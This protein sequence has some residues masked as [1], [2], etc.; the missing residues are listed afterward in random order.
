MKVPAE[1]LMRTDSCRVPVATGVLALVALGEIAFCVAVNYLTIS[2]ARD[3]PGADLEWKLL[4]GAACVDVLTATY[5]IFFVA[6]RVSYA[7]ERMESGHADQFARENGSGRPENESVGCHLLVY[8]NFVKYVIFSTIGCSAFIVHFFRTTE[9]SNLVFSSSAER[10]LVISL[11]S[12]ALI[13]AVL[14]PVYTSVWLFN[15]DDIIRYLTGKPTEAQP[16]SSVSTGWAGM[17]NLRPKRSWFCMIPN[18]KPRV[19]WGSMMGP[20][21]FSTGLSIYGSIQRN[22][23]VLLATSLILSPPLLSLTFC[24]MTVQRARE[25]HVRLHILQPDP[26]SPPSN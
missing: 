11:L 21:I 25:D 14:I 22:K 23:R 8:L 19:V 20:V 1:K 13:Y 16:S 10:R 6:L 17:R 4:L 3:T 26:E 5:E 2:A 18:R 12:L 15:D 24:F 9:R 7:L